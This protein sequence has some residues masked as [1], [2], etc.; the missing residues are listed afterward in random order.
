V[1]TTRFP[2]DA[3]SRYAREKDFEEWKDRLMIF[4]LDLRDLAALER[5]CDLLNAKLP[6]LDMIVN[7]ACQTIRRP[8]SYYSHLMA[9]ERTPIADLPGAMG[10]LLTANEEHASRTRQLR[11]EGSKA[12]DGNA[13]DGNARDSNARGSAGAVEGGR[14]GGVDRHVQIDVSEGEGEFAGA[15]APDGTPSGIACMGVVVDDVDAEKAA[16]E[17]RA[18]R[19]AANESSGRGAASSST[20]SS[21]TALQTARAVSELNSAEQSQVVLH[22]DD[23]VSEAERKRLYP[24][25]KLDVNR[26]QLDLR[27]RNSWLLKLEEVDT[28]EVAEVFAIN[29][30]AP[31]VINSRLKPLMMRSKRPPGIEDGADAI[32]PRFIVNVS[33]MEGKFY[34]HKSA[35]HPHTNMA[36]AALN[37]MTRTSAESYAKDGIYMN[38]ADTGWIND[39]NPLARAAKIAEKHNFQTPIDEIDAAARVLDTIMVGLNGGEC[40]H[41]KFLKDYFPTQW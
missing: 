30:L 7:N 10:R 15:G 4:G 20:A 27:T 26:Q 38:S 18:A 16:E 28:P 17:A 21:S 31:F 11:L 9:F 19:A 22:R 8:V 40:V 6:R 2:K 29:T 39:E 36:K 24:E 5:F 32:A 37:M 35:A 1:A 14:P 33:A 3:A 12:R 23:A 13:R 25:G 41:G 34:R